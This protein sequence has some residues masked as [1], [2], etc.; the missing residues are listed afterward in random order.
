MVDETSLP[1]GISQTVAVYDRSP[2]GIDVHTSILPKR[3]TSPRLLARPIRGNERTNSID[4]PRAPRP[5]AG[6]NLRIPRLRVTHGPGDQHGACSSTGAG[7][8]VHTASRTTPLGT[9]QVRYHVA[10]T[11]LATA[12]GG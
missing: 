5:G 4:D 3:I 12:A 11:P 7:V 6:P 1:P 10:L 2:M 9:I 8:G